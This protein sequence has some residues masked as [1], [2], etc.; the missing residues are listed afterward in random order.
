M[1]GKSDTFETD[2]LNLLFK[3]TALAGIGDASG[4]QP[5]AAAG[6]L[7]LSLHT[8]DP[9]DAATQATSEVAYTG[10]ARKAV[11]RG[12]GFNVAGNVASTAA[13]NDFGECTASPGS[14]ATYY[15]IGTA[16]SGAGKLL[17]SGQLMDPTFTTPQP[18]AIAIGTIPR[19]KAGTRVTED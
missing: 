11:A 6:S 1:A 9:G 19:L 17:Y 13:D 4:L 12:A 3:N 2:L 18:I 14:P 8:A 15:G 10:Y 7:Y 16:S 5:S